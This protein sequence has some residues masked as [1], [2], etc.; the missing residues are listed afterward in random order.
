V[1]LRFSNIPLQQVEM[2]LYFS[3]KHSISLTYR[4]I[5]HFYG[6]FKDRFPE[7]LE[8]DNIETNRASEHSVKLGLLAP[9]GVIY[10]NPDD[11]LCLKV[12]ANMIK[13]EW[14]RQGADGPEYP[15]FEG[16]LVELRN[17]VET[18]E[19]ELG[20]SL[21]VRICNMTYTKII[22]GPQGPGEDLLAKYYADGIW[23]TP[24]MR[25]HVFHEAQI[26]WRTESTVDLRLQVQYGS[27]NEAEGYLV[28]EHGG[29]ELKDQQTAFD[30]L[31]AV[32][33]ELESFMKESLSET[34]KEEWGYQS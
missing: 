13:L 6:L 16:L 33:S 2:R 31:I 24:V 10:A 1:S 21:P 4:L 23:G 3:G 22:L 26:G 8:P 12:Q 19:T 25:S 5:V 18:F 15:G 34:A 30:G 9:L 28:S 17:V 14:N 27:A 7:L 32:H 29:V 20:Y 11:G